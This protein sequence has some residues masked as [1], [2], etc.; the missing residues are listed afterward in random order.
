MIPAPKLDDRI[1]LFFAPS[2]ACLI[3]DD[4]GV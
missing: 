3:A 2:D 4:P 1:D